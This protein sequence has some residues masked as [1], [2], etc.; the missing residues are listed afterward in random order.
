[1]FHQKDLDNLVRW[2]R[3]DARRHT[4]RL[5]ESFSIAVGVHLRKMPFLHRSFVIIDVNVSGLADGKAESLLLEAF[6]RHSAAALKEAQEKR[7]RLEE[8]DRKRKEKAELER[9][10]EEEEMKKR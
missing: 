2:G 3:S 7:K 10:R 5:K 8:M 1:M 4:H 6:R 9:K